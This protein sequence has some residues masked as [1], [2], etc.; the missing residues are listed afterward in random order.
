MSKMYD[1]AGTAASLG[2]V[3]LSNKVLTAGWK[4]VTGNEPPAKNPD[5]DEAWRD[6][7]VWALLTGLVGTI[8]KVGVQRAIAKMDTD[9]D[10][11]SQSEI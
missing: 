8:I 1:L 3:A 6:I 7:I 4:K 10:N 9:Q 11:T 5:P 2:G